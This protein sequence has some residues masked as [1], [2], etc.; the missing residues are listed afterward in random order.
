MRRASWTLTI[1]PTCPPP[2]TAFAEPLTCLSDAGYP[3]PSSGPRMRETDHLAAHRLVR[4][5]PMKAKLGTVLIVDD[6]ALLRAS[7]ESALTVVGYRVLS[8][9]DP[10]EAYSLLRAT[11]PDAVLLDVRLPGTSGPAMSSVIAR[12][13]PQLEG[14]IAFMT[15]DAGAEDVRAWLECNRSPLLRKPFTVRQIPTWL[16]ATLRPALAQTSESGVA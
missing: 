10:D 5:L 6:D 8:C 16:D 11:S 7:L 1:K 4:L 12:R 14:R 2:S 15:G 9:A 3:P 13:W